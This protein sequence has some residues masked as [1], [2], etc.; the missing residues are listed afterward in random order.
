MPKSSGEVQR[1]ANAI[2]QRIV[3]G[4]YPAGLRLPAETDLA[5]QFRCGRSTVREALRHLASMGL[6]RSRRGSGALVRDFRTEGTPAL[7]PAFLEAGRFDQPLRV[8]ATELLRIRTGMA[9]EA[10]RLAACYATPEQLTDAHD[11]LRRAPALESDPIEH[12]ANELGLYRALVAASG[13]WPAV[14]LVNSFWGPLEEIHRMLAPALGPVRPAFQPTMER[15][16]ALIEQRDGD[17]AVRLVRRW[18]DEV[19]RDLVG[20][21]ERAVAA[22]GASSPN[23][24][25]RPVAPPAAPASLPAPDDRRTAPERSTVPDS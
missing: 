9:C 21:L 8:M 5:E 16:L 4:S 2:L 24:D 25:D 23:E 3:D 1:L 11:R 19:D 10:V 15:L 12:A 7:L 20:A 14:W 6:I 13:I 18:F 17:E 22:L